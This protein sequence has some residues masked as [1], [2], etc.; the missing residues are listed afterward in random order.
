MILILHRKWLSKDCTIGEL[1]IGSSTER[2]CYILEPPVREIPG[3]PVEKWKVPGHT[4]VPKGTY[5]IERRFSPKHGKIV[6]WLCG[7][8]GF[9]DVEIHSGNT[10]VDTEGCLLPGLYKDDDNTKVI[11][12]VAAF[13]GLDVQLKAAEQR[14]EEIF[15]TIS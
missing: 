11:E 15:I 13:L 10:A 8:P 7:I 14:H 12:S 9:E 6:P 5:K 2:E 3:V 4:A 1:S